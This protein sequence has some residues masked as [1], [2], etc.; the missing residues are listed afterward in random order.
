[1]DIKTIKKFIRNI[2]FFVILIVLTFWIIFKD[3]DMNELFNI[4]RMAKKSYVLLGFFVMLLFFF[5]EAYNIKSILKTF[6]E[7]IS[8][9]KA[10]K[11]TLIGFFFSAI[12]PAASG[13]QPM[14]I[15]YMKKEKISGA[16]A[17]MAL[18]IQLCGFQI[19]TLSLGIICAIINPGILKGG[20]LFLFL[21]GVTIN[22]FALF[23]M[24]VCVFSKRLTAKLINIFVKIM[25]FFKVK[26]IEKKQEDLNR[27]LE[28]YNNNSE[29]IKSHKKE[30][31]ICILRVFVQIILYYLVPICVY[32]S[33]GLGEYNI[34]QLLTMQA[35]LYTTVSGLPLP[36][37][38]GI[39]E[40]VFLGIFGVAFGKGLLQSAVLLNRGISFYGFVIISLIVVII[41]IIR[42]KRVSKREGDY[43]NGN[44]N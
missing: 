39:S 42:N 38:I 18:L 34:F 12:T 27:G 35:V 37:A 11:F 31:V 28:K 6:G 33:F 3:Q 8:I 24:L 20:L 22:G 7:K 23:L 15:Y 9:F 41:N 36:G 2:I 1:M 17:T 30:F 32:N 44:V 19:S 4:I 25:R 40:S 14:E 43:E 21:V 26:N 29:Y 10:Y 16:H 5:M 13:G